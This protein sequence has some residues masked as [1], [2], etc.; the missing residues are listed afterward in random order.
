MILQPIIIWVIVL[1]LVMPVRWVRIVGWVMIAVVLVL[2]YVALV[3]WWV[4]YREE[5]K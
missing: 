5:D 3:L 4:V 2:K 1:R